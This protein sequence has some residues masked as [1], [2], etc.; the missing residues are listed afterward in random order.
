MCVKQN[1]QLNSELNNKVNNT[2]FNALKS[3]IDLNRNSS[4]NKCS[5]CY[6]S[7]GIAS[8]IVYA[9]ASDFPT[10]VDNTYGLIFCIS[11]WDGYAVQIVVG[12]SKTALRR[13]QA[14]SSWTSWQYLN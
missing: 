10:N 14:G 7:K 6:I 8:G 3:Q 1:Y 9:T 2:V 11:A 4:F 5:D 13:L 12:T